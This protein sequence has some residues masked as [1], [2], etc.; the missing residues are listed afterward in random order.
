M[1]AAKYQSVLAG[2]RTRHRV[3]LGRRSR[4][5]RRP[6]RRAR[7]ARRRPGPAEAASRSVRSPAP[8]VADG[9]GGERRAIER[10]HRC[11][12]EPS[13]VRTI[14]A[15]ATVGLH[16]HDRV[17]IGRTEVRQRD[18]LIGGRERRRQARAVPRGRDRAP[19]AR[20]LRRVDRRRRRR[21][22]DGCERPA[23]TPTRERDDHDHEDQRST[24]ASPSATAVIPASSERAGSADAGPTPDHERDDPQNDLERDRANPEANPRGSGGRQTRAPAARTRSSSR[25]RCCAT[26]S[27]PAGARVPAAGRPP[28]PRATCPGTDRSGTGH[29]PVHTASRRGRRRCRAAI[30][31]PA[32]GAGVGDTDVLAGNDRA[33]RDP[34]VV[35]VD[36]RHRRRYATPTGRAAGSARRRA[37]DRPG[38]PDRDPAPA[39]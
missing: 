28:R 8:P 35:G 3:E 19:G 13:H 30:S 16:G 20:A 14:G 22:R 17:G 23:T 38:R 36:D 25:T 6:R 1:P 33:A 32:A 4:P 2:V 5:R 26:R 37:S 15:G 24:R 11:R 21:G 29:R 18:R 7:T 31:S 34:R 39:G 10:L 12:A 9:H 27:W